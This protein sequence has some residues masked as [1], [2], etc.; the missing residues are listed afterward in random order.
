VE[1]GLGRVVGDE[2]FQVFSIGNVA[3]LEGESLG[4]GLPKLVEAPILESGVVERVE[5][6]ETEYLVAL[7]EQV[8]GGLPSDEAGGT[9]D[10]IGGDRQALPDGVGPSFSERICLT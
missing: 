9:G 7:F 5:V 1:H 10:E 8:L 2:A 3:L 6:I 4:V